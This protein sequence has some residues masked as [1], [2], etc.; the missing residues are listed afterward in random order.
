MLS[1][2]A[3]IV[4]AQPADPARPP[5]PLNE[6]PS[7]IW[8]DEDAALYAGLALDGLAVQPLVGEVLEANQTLVLQKAGHVVLLTGERLVTLNG[9][10]TW[11][12]VPGALETAFGAQPSVQAGAYREGPMP[13]FEPD[14]SVPDRGALGATLAFVEPRSPILRTAPREL[15][16]RWPYAGGRFDLTLVRID[17]GDEIVERWRNIEG[18]SHRLWTTLIPGASYRVS[19]A[20]GSEGDVS[21]IADTQVFRV[22]SPT[23]DATL[24]ASLNALQSRAGERYRPELDV[25]KARLFESHGLWA[26]AESLWTGL[27]ILY[28]SRTELLHHA[29]RLHRRGMDQRA[30]A[31]D[32]P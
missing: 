6:P 13:L 7:I 18:R 19:I 25:L 12:L 23:E 28:P 29:L 5:L 26:Q 24:D 22:L 32:L 11:R 2:F 4:F 16:W 31:A 9:P 1:L 3:L 14:A 27:A 10:G 30:G 15:T 21:A 20:L 8:A 17:G